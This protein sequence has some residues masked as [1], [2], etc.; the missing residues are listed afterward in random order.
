MKADLKKYR[1]YTILFN[2]IE[3]YSGSYY[4]IATVFKSGEEAFSIDINRSFT[5]R[6]QALSFA[7]GA[8]ENTINAM[9][10]GEEVEFG[11]NRLK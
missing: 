1:D 2:A 8:S 5:D 11:I 4:P 10:N 3:L 6:D 9:I 7:L